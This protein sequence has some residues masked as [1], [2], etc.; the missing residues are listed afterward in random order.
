MKYKNIHIGFFGTSEY[1]V[2]TLKELKKNDYSIDFVVTTPDRPKGRGMVIMASPAKKWAEQNKIPVQ[3]P[4]SL[5]NNPGLVDT[6]K[7]FKCNVF[8][9]IDYGKIIPQEILDIPSGKSL[10]IHASLLPKFRGSCPI[11][12]SILEDE[13]QTGVTI[14]R[15]DALL[16]HGPIV[17]MKKVIY[18]PWP[19]TS[20]EL[21][22][23]LV[24]EGNKLL[25]KILPDWIEGK[26][27]EVE[28]DHT[29]AT[30]TKK[31][32]KEDGLLELADIFPDAPT[33][34]AYTAFRKI[35]AYHSWPGAYFFVEKKNPPKI[36]MRVKIT[37]ASWQNDKLIIEKVIP[38][39][40]KEMSYKD[41]S[42]R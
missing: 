23:A 6:L 11:E 32:V 14:M 26:I 28:Q 33:E 22:T 29:Q 30:F 38:E 3:Q 20:E 24:N 17:V 39:G 8:V 10:N 5:R 2:M 42:N 36:I 41:F 16:D 40:K 34:R 35:Q 1:A 25:I 13:K 27:K 4:E 19:P 18:E 31:I 15:M 9:V 12:T 37:S 21:G 7:K